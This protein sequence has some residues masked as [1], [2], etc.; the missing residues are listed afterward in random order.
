MPLKYAIIDQ[1][2]EVNVGLTGD[3]DAHAPQTFNEIAG[4]LATG[5]TVVFH[6]GRVAS[7]NSLGA[8]AWINAMTQLGKRYSIEY[9]ECPLVMVEYTRVLP[10]FMPSGRITS[11]HAA[12]SCRICGLVETK[13]VA[14]S[15]FNADTYGTQRCAKCGAALEP[16][17]DA[18]DY[19][20]L[21]GRGG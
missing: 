21:F 12:F 17:L 15:G 13:V 5:K 6:C 4:R 7:I 11:A 8:R 14:A 3:L 2:T 16:D 1:P 20:Q 19:Q 18:E 10:A 9:R